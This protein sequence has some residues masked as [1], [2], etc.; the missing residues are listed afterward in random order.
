MR[1]NKIFFIA[2]ISAFWLV[3]CVEEE[4]KFT[5]PYSKVYFQIDINGIDS[6][7]TPFGYKAFTKPR[8]IGEQVGYGG[9]LIFRTV[10]DEIFAYDL[11][12]PY[13]KERTV[14]VHPESNGQ[15]VCKTCG[16][17]FVIMYGRVEAGVIMQ[18]LGTPLKGPATSHLQSY[19]VR[20][21]PHRNGVFVIS[22]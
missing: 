20:A 21:L 14:T 8:V 19:P 3:A 17:S 9:L 22:N 11:S 12:C 1:A 4:S 13:E 7:L 6:D 10:Q 15:A 5:L 16:S 2:F 18:G